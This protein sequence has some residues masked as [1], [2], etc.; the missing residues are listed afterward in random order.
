MVRKAE[1]P[2]SRH[3]IMIFDEDWEFLTQAFGAGSS[4]PIGPGNAIK[5]L[6]HG[7]V[8]KIKAQVEG[9]AHRRDEI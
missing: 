8:S 3:H 5:T 1:L 4:K 6:V 7:Y 2:Q 9:T